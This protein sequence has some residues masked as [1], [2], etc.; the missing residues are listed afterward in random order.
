MTDPVT[1]RVDVSIGDVHHSQLVVGD[2]NTIQ[3]PK[4]TKVTLLQVGERPVPRLRPMPV[5]RRPPAVEIVGRDEDLGL[6]VSAAA[7]E[8]VQFYASDGAGKTSLLKLA[9]SR[10]AP[11]AEGVVFESTRRRSLDEIQAALYA[12]FWECEVPFLPGPA[13]VGE[14][15]AEREALLVLDDCGLDRSE[16]EALLDHVPRCAVVLAGEERTLWS[17]GSAHRLAD[18]DPDAAAQ[19]LERELGH[20]LDAAERGA[21]EAVVARLGGNPQSL[22]EVAALLEDG[23][24]SL[25][26]LAEDPEALERRMDPAALTDSQRRILDVLAL[27]DGAPLGVEHVAALAHVGDAQAAL[28]DLERRGWAKAASPRYRSV[29]RVSH[30]PP[31]SGELTARLI[32]HLAAWSRRAEPAEIAAETEAVERALELGAAAEDWGATLVLALAAQ[33]GLTVAGAWSGCRRVLAMGLEAAGKVGSEEVRAYFLHQLGS[34][35]LCLG[36]LPDATH[37]LT[38][39]LRLREALGDHDGAELTRHN[40]D[41]LPGGGSG[42]NGDGGGPPRPRTAI[43]IAAGLVAVAG[44]VVA[45]A[46]GSGGTD[47]G[48]PHHPDPSPASAS[49]EPSSPNPSPTGTSPASEPSSPSSDRAP[50]GIEDPGEVESPPT[51]QSQIEKKA[52]SPDYQPPLYVKP[53]EKIVK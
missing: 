3:T 53:T 8:A 43:A 46:G 19:L 37:R 52:L 25:T 48:A 21:A 50:T 39:A 22:V 26:E 13:Q 32:E 31:S 10:A 1:S 44:I 7:G 2:H 36:D 17:R 40:L 16:L 23:R 42:G 28:R 12:A 49:P 47:A 34:Q 24:G 45:V 20:P 38:E 51:E 9:A 29:R 4:G 14:F 5:Q 18:L 27:L 6:A 35:S 11:P 15:L 30:D 33:G 41:Q